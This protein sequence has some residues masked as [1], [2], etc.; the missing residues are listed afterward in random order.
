MLFKVYFP[1][2]ISHCCIYFLIWP[3][4]LQEF[5]NTDT[6]HNVHSFRAIGKVCSADYFIDDEG[7]SFPRIIV[8]LL[9]FYC[10]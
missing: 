6:Q 7:M 9:L 10:M 4:F 8:Q 1:L 2:V 3:N 5:K